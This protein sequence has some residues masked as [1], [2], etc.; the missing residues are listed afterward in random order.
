MLKYSDPVALDSAAKAELL[1]FAFGLRLE[2][3]S[4]LPLLHPLHTIDGIPCFDTVGFVLHFR[5]V[6]TTA[7]HRRLEQPRVLHEISH[8][9]GR[10]W[11]TAGSREARADQT[12]CDA[13]NSHAQSNV[14]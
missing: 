9:Y 2:T 14:I 12:D 13:Y 8:R 7:D 5:A 11:L 10:R 6:P 1:A 3:G 4:A